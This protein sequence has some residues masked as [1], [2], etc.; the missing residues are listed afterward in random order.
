MIFQIRHLSSLIRWSI[1]VRYSQLWEAHLKLETVFPDLPEIPPKIA[2]WNRT[3]EAEL[4]RAQH[5]EV[6][7]EQLLSRPDLRNTPVL[8]E[9]LD[10]DMFER[11]HGVD[12]HF[13]ILAN[14]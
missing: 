13:R 3:D 10:L 7:L 9:L 14:G 1:R 5:I 12:P 4:R 11:P 2:F 8:S 6:Y